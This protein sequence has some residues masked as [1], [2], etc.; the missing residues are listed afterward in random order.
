M[1]AIMV[2]ALAQAACP[3]TSRY[4]VTLSPSNTQG[5][6]ACGQQ[7][8]TF[9]NLLNQLMGTG[10]VSS[11]QAK[12]IMAR[13]QG[14]LSPGAGG[15]TGYGCGQN[16]AGCSQDYCSPTGC[17]QGSCGPSGCSQDTCNP[18]GCGQGGYGLSGLLSGFGQGSPASSGCSQ[19]T[20]GYGF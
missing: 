15:C 16:Q 20:C 5:S 13:L 12:A 6:V 18:T 14:Y 2:P 4:G 10:F 8:S 19:G 11:E 3:A 17:S 1:F 9:Q 7:T